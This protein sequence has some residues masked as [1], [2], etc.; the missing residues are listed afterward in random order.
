MLK[1]QRFGSSSFS[2]EELEEVSFSSQAIYD[3]LYLILF[4]NFFSGSLFV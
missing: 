3:A 1:K 2:E 4:P